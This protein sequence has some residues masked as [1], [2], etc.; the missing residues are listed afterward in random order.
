[1]PRQLWG[2]IKETSAKENETEKMVP[3]AAK[4]SKLEEMQERLPSSAKKR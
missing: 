4:R 1:M 3:V 2:K